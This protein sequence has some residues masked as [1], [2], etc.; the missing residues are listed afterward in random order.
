[1]SSKLTPEAY[2]DLGAGI[3]LNPE[4]NGVSYTDSNFND[5]VF[6]GTSRPDIQSV[7]ETTADI[8]R[9]SVKLKDEL[10]HDTPTYAD[11]FIRWPEHCTLEGPKFRQ[12]DLGSQSSELDDFML[13]TMPEG[14][15]SIIIDTIDK[16]FGANSEN[17]KVLVIYHKVKY[18]K[19]LDKGTK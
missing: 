9:K 6:A 11:Q 18:R 4:V 10:W 13:Q 16:Q 1:M 3:T 2:L 14:A 7:H 15:P 8:K 19:L 5:A 17:W 12:F